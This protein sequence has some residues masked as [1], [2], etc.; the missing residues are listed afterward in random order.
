V[1]KV[2][3]NKK[4]SF[5]VKKCYKWSFTVFALFRV[6]SAT[7]THRFA[8]NRFGTG[9]ETGFSVHREGQGLLRVLFRLQ[10]FVVLFWFWQL[11]Y[12]MSLFG[13]KRDSAFF[14]VYKKVLWCLG[15]SVHR[16]SLRSQVEPPRVNFR[17]VFLPFVPDA[18]AKNKLECLSLAC[19]SGWC[20]LGSEGG[21]P[22]C[23]IYISKNA[24][25]SGCFL[26]WLLG[27]NNSKASCTLAILS[28]TI[29]SLLTLD[30]FSETT[31]MGL[32]L[33]V[34]YRQR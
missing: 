6:F 10:I 13:V 3:S 25:D 9:F 32:F 28:V 27:A 24:S 18:E 26:S 12:F 4:S 2:V 22:Y 11:I 34:L 33:L 7:F 1:A 17:K 8:L 14:V 21:P 29:Q 31:P 16:R 5:F 19:F 30:T 23:S 15:L 20:I